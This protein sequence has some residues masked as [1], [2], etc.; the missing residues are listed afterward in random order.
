MES[1]ISQT[2]WSTDLETGIDVVDEQ[3]HQYFN[4]LNDYLEK[5]AEELT[6]RQQIIDLA[7]KF[8]FLRQYAKGHFSTEESIM[9]NAG[10]PDF[11]FHYGEHLSFLRHV[12]EL[13]IQLITNGYN[14]QLAREVITTRLN[15]LS[16]IFD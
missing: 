11:E 12:E 4:L 16:N 13:Y 1:E 8:D 3:H 6:D 2:A 9:K 7:E 10:Y 14:S 15:G 5:A